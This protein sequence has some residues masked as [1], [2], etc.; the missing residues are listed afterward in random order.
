M[1][2]SGP[3]LYLN[4]FSE[5]QAEKAWQCA[6]RLAQGVDTLILDHHLMRGHRGVQWLDRLCAA[7]KKGVLCGADFMKKPRMLLEARRKQLYEQIPVAQGWHQAY[8]K[9]R[10]STEAYRG[11]ATRHMNEPV[12]NA[13]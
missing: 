4:S 6:V 9:G 13:N 5:T 8:A 2:A 3:P 1:L 12:L 7:T 10:V 11:Y